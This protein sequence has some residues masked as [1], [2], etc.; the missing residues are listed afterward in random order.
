M[1][2]LISVSC[3]KFEE[4]TTTAPA[5]KPTFKVTTSAIQ[6]TIDASKAYYS[7][8]NA[9]VS[10]SSNPY[11][12]ISSLLVDGV[13][14]TST[15]DTIRFPAIAADHTIDIKYKVKTDSL[16]GQWNFKATLYFEKDVLP[17]ATNNLLNFSELVLVDSLKSVSVS[18]LNDNTIT[19]DFSKITGS[20][21]LLE[22]AIFIADS[23][24]FIVANTNNVATLS[25]I[26]ID[27]IENILPY[28]PILTSPEFNE[29]TD[30][31][32][33]IKFRKD[34]LGNPVYTSSLS[35]DGK[36]I[37]LD[38]D[39]SFYYKIYDFN[40]DFYFGSQSYLMFIRR[41]PN[42]Y[43]ADGNVYKIYSYKNSNG[44]NYAKL[45]YKLTK[46]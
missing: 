29:I 23:L 3:S 10:Y 26:L 1:L 46:N 25:K 2:I 40:I 32:I 15:N 28:E 8:T 22:N 44:D 7:G 20:K 12:T 17:T 37:T 42:E 16:S 34:A 41:L 45:T 11:F 18:K 5:E 33:A 27:T 38:F 13:A 36:T 6:G 21:P 43:D 30:A 24:N 31:D 9:T 4:Q 39:V 19:C 35:A 14:S